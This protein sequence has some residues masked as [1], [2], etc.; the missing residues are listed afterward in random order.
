MQVG[1]ML[2]MK[3]PALRLASG[4]AASDSC[5]WLRQTLANTTPSASSAARALVHHRG[6]LAEVD[7]GALVDRHD[8]GGEADLVGLPRQRLA[9]RQVA[10]RAWHVDAVEA[11]PLGLPAEVDGGPAAAGHGDQAE[12]G[13]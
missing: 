2:P 6:A 11:P 7:Q 9:H 8:R 1:I 13:Q 12:G 10:H 4:S 3:K 5:M